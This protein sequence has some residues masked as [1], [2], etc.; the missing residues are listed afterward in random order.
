[1]SEIKQ[2]VLEAIAEIQMRFPGHTVESEGDSEGGA[3]VIVQGLDIG[4]Q[5][6]PDRSWVGFRITFQYP[7]ADV[8][9]HYLVSELK[10]RDGRGLGEAFHPNHRFEP[11]AGAKPATMVSRR[12]N[13]RDPATETAALKL[14]KVLEWI[15]SR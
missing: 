2:A 15:R 12:S 6:E 11:P 9:P 13:R 8:Y 4:G 10:R 3:F 5:Y 1:M 14:A 7:F